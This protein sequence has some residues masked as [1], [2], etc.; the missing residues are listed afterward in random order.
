MKGE[1]SA[2][3]R[4]PFEREQDLAA[5]LRVHDPEAWQQLFR[6][7]YQ[8]VYNY[9]YLRTGNTADA[10]DIASNV[11]AEAARG[12]DRF[13]YQGAP[14]AAWIFRIAHHETVDALK[15]RKRTATVSIDEPAAADTLQARDEFASADEWRDVSAAMGKLKQEHRDVLML[16]LVEGHSVTEVAVLLGKTEGAVKVMQMRAL[17]SLRGKLLP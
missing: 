9:A 15:R 16:R 12:I 3:Q 2:P 7:Q 4:Q 14:V 6:E 13:R 11:F 10:D 8:R 1:D 17:H 5:A